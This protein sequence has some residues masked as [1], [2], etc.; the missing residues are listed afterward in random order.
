MIKDDNNQTA[1]AC[2]N[3]YELHRAVWRRDLDKIRELLDRCPDLDINERDMHGNPALHIA[4]HL[5]Y[6]DV[7]RLLLSRGADPTYKNGGMWS[8]L[9]EAVAS[10]ER[11]LVA[12]IMLAVKN[13]VGNEFEKRLPNLLKA[14]EEVLFIP[15]LL[16]PL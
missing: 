3:K 15:P 10:G 12:Q 8:P 11:K 9:Q 1:S 5:R 16:W 14:V 7:V 13:H 2:N 6:R 4:I